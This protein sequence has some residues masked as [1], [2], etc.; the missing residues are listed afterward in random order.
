WDAG[1]L[2]WHMTEVQ[3]SWEWVITNR[4]AIPKEDPPL[5]RPAEYA[6]LLALFDDRSAA[7]ATTL[8]SAD[9]GEEAWSWSTDHT[10]G[11]TYR[12]QAHEALIHRLDA[13][14]T[15]GAVTDLDAR[16]AGDGV[17][18]ALAV[19]FGGCPPWGTFTPEEG[20][21]RVDVIDTDQ[22][23]WV[24]LGRFTGTDP[25]DG[26]YCAERDISVVDNPGDEPDA[27]V[28]GPAAVLDTWLWRRGDDSEIR[29]AGDRGVYDRFRATIDQ[30]IN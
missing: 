7:F 14:L 10:V 12:R 25:D 28:A 3:N 16:L 26:K 18:E 5:V 4:P 19:M 24:Q 23:V 6:D 8:G 22:Q 21:L 30:P 15:V 11:F 2:L 20:L 17:E 1:E 13:E 27:V 29:V 9:P